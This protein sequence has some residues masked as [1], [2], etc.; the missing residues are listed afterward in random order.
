[1]AKI[2]FSFL[3]VIVITS[4][5][6]SSTNI[7]RI[8]KMTGDVKVLKNP[9]AK[10]IS[11]PG[12][13]VLFR[14]KYYTIEKPRL[15]FKVGNGNIV[16]TGHESKVRI[17]FKNGDQY[18]VASGTAYEVAW[19]K[20]VG[21]KKGSSIINLMRGQIRA[22]VSKKGPRNNLKV[23]TRYA[24]MGVRGTDFYVSTKGASGSTKVS[25]LRGEVEMKVQPKA[26]QSKV[27]KAIKIN[28]PKAIKVK[29]GFTAKVE[30]PVKQV[31]DAGNVAKIKAPIAKPGIVNVVKTNKRELVK[32]QKD[33][34][35]KVK[36]S[37]RQKVT[38][39]VAEEIKDLNKKAIETTLEDIKEYDPNLYAEIKKKPVKS[40]AAVNSSVVKKV[41]RKAP[42]SAEKPGVDDLENIE[43]DAYDRYFSID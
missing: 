6:Y 12:P 24:S 43:E 19:K 40:I 8:I 28:P 22:V 9:S 31:V 16:Q 7:G 14:K 23:K 38:K 42:K 33:S 4:V 36:K 30:A 25:V 15:G 3:L 26:V 21:K 17:V 35:I 11:G 32:I 1:M 41:F 10:K 39:A 20:S 27:A 18:N 13:H 5:A 34:M 37:E 29:S 2:F